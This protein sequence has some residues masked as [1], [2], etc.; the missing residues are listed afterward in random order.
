MKT[1]TRPVFID[2]SQGRLFGLYFPATVPARG[3]FLYLP[4]FAEEMNRCRALASAQAR[5]FARIGYSCLLLD[6]FGTGESH[7]ELE[8]ASWD[9]WATDAGIAADWLARESGLCV[10]LWGMRLGGLLAG[11]MFE[12]APS[13][14]G[15]LLLWQPVV[16]GKQFLTQY[17]R[18]RVAWL[19][20]RGLPAETTDLIRGR[21]AEGQVVEVAGYPLAGQLAA[22]IDAARLFSGESAMQAKRIDW[23]ENVTNDSGA[24]SIAARQ[25]VSALEARGAV[26]GSHP[27]S[28]PPLWQLHERDALPTLISA[29][30][31]LFGESS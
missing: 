11:S 25:V 29:T 16:N 7:G 2:G 23:F 27:F 30:T 18:L 26:V 6:P 17:L 13:R 19:M 28:G 9:L 12:S 20:E 4:P 8:A 21:M 3:A 5:S 1:E 24:L 15:R 14:Y 10:S 31:A 22:G